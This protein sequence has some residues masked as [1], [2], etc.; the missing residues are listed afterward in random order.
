MTVVDYIYPLTT[1]NRNFDDLSRVSIQKVGRLLTSTRKSSGTHCNASSESLSICVHRSELLPDRHVLTRN[2]NEKFN[3]VCVP[4]LANSDIFSA[5]FA[6]L[7]NK[8][9]IL[10]YSY[11]SNFDLVWIYFKYYLLFLFN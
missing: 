11:G 9:T 8:Q 3:A 10:K 5:S 2:P 4:I 1:C 6:L 7:T